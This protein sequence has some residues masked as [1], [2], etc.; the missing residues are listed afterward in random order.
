MACVL[1]NFVHV[2]TLEGINKTN[3]YMKLT[4]SIQL[5]KLYCNSVFIK[6]LPQCYKWN[7]LSNEVHHEYLPKTLSY[8]G[9]AIL[10]DKY[11]CIVMCFLSD[12]SLFM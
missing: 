1:I 5:N 10:A 3:V 12:K 9:N 6:H 11:I 8:V 2:S 7:G 4:L